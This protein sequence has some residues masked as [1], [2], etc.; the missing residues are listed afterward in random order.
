[1]RRP[2]LERNV[3]L[4]I[5]KCHYEVGPERVAAFTHRFRRALGRS[6]RPAGSF[7]LVAAGA[8]VG[9]CAWI[10]ADRWRGGGAVTAA[11]QEEAAPVPEREEKLKGGWSRLRD[12]WRDFEQESARPELDDRTLQRF[13]RLNEAFHA[14]GLYEDPADYT[15]GA[16]KRLFILKIRRSQWMSADACRRCHVSLPEEFGPGL[17][18]AGALPGDEG[19]AARVLGKAFRASRLADDQTP[20]WLEGRLIRLT[21][22]LLAGADYPAPARPAPEEGRRIRALIRS[23]GSERVEDREAAT[24]ALMAIGE[25]AEGFLR[26]AAAGGD[27]ERRHR[28][29]RI[30]GAGHRPWAPPAADPCPA[31]D[32]KPGAA[33]P[34]GGP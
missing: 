33:R 6:R 5:R 9:L 16:L 19:E 32:G 30:L 28:I 31:L 21:R 3:E 7:P 34:G 4:L 22:A 20:A 1:M 23:L 24:A 12:A 26:A 11:P 18:S 27:P 2:V 10:A 25:R 13:A 29:A 8:V 17:P 14:A 15:A